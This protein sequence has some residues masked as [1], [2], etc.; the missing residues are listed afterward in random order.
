MDNGSHKR[1]N[2]WALEA[3]DVAA[4]KLDDDVDEPEGKLEV[5]QVQDHPEL[6]DLVHAPEKL[7]EP[8]HGSIHVWLKD[9][10]RGARGFELGTLNSSLLAVTMKRQ[11]TKWKSL[12]LGYIADIVT[13]TH[14]FVT[15]L[16]RVVCPV[17]RVQ[18]GVMSLLSDHLLEKYDSAIDHVKF[19]LKIEL[20]GTPA[21]LNHYFN[22]NLE[23]CHPMSNT[24]HAIQDL[25]DIL[26]S[27]YKVAL[28]RFVD[29]LRMQAADHFLITGSRTPLTLFSPAFVAGMTPGQL[30]EVAGEDLTI[31]RKRAQLEKE[32]KDLEDG[33]KILS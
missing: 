13:L 28:K 5:R 4:V 20:D 16:L 33:K 22:E 7:P 32:Q 25:H 2:G 26:H 23:K 21:T 18:L 29:A 24:D 3:P 6:K 12:A 30:E 14:Y 19:L 27:N 15:D 31:K 11:S 17:E 10:Y 8:Q 9:V 1:S